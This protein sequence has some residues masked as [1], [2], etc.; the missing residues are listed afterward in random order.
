MWNS[1]CYMIDVGLN[2]ATRQLL[3]VAIKQTAVAHLWLF[4]SSMLGIYLMWQKSTKV[5]WN[6]FFPCQTI[7]NPSHSVLHVQRNVS[8][9]VRF[10]ARVREIV[11]IG[12]ARSTPIGHT[13]NKVIRNAL[14]KICNFHKNVHWLITA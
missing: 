12:H 4:W 2:G 8:A 10:Y 9:Q 13:I 11:A 6:A 14:F 1:L 3:A 7:N 5:V